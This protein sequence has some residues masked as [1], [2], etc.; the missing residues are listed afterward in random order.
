MY[1]EVIGIVGLA[2]Q[3]TS[4]FFKRIVDAFPGEKDWDRPQVIINN[5]CII[6]SRVRAI[7]YGENDDRIKRELEE[8]VRGILRCAGKKKVRMVIDCNTAH[9]YIGY[10]KE[11]IPEADF[12]DI[13]ETCA[14]NLSER[15]IK[16]VVLL[17]SEGIFE[18]KIYNRYFE[19]KGIAIT[20][21][22]SKMKEIRYFIECVKQNKIT[23]EAKV[24]FLALLRSFEKMPIILGCTE[25]PVLYEKIQIL[26]KERICAG[27]EH[28]YD[29]L[30][31]V[32]EKLKRELK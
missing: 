12:I 22:A 10:L 32:L 31:C 6:P 24:R 1:S 19:E 29:P 7:L 16:E 3:A 28:V 13:I 11:V 26:D 23:E 14:E 15:D 9:H 25:L 30:E 8:C 20:Y 4:H 21:P 5:D 18:T 17:A 27:G 2:S